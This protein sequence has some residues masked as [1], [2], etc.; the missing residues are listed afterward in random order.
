[1][2][3]RPGRSEFAQEAIGFLLASYLRLVET[4][5]RKTTVPQDLDAFI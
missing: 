3:R 2:A 5:S 4:T 1:M